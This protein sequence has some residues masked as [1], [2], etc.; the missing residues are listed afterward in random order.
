VKAPRQ[1]AF[2]LVELVVSLAIVGLLATLA[3]P[4]FGRLMDRARSASCMGNL[5]AIGAAVSSYISDNEGRLPHVNNPSPWN[6]YDEDTPLPDDAEPVTLAE[7]IASYGLSEQALRCP[8]DVRMNNRFAQS[9]TSYEWIPRID[10]EQS[11]APRVL[12][13]RRGLVNRN[14][15]RIIILRDFDLVHFGRSNRL[16]GD[17][18][19]VMVQR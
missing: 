6:V 8:G 13:R 19:A 16:Y 12:S 17:G 14:L 10:G 9:G 11:I 3:L 7:V 15:S 1:S 5:R 18:R 2:T 4:E